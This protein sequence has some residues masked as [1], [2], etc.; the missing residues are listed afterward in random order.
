MELG[1]LAVALEDFRNVVRID[2]HNEQAWAKLSALGDAGGKTLWLCD[3]LSLT[4]TEGT[5]HLLCVLH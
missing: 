1:E 4:H 3:A 2:P 5:H